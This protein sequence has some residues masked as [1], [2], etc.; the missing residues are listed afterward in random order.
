MTSRPLWSLGI[1]QEFEPVLSLAAEPFPKAPVIKVSVQ[2][3][4]LVIIYSDLTSPTTFD[5]PLT[6]F[7]DS[8]PFW[9]FTGSLPF[10][11]RS[12]EPL[13]I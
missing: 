1:G 2:V 11:L 13:P 10:E 6:L 3:E 5:F 9:L 8:M 12:W 7:I 4:A